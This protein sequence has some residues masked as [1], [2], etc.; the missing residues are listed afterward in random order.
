MAQTKWRVVVEL[1]TDTEQNDG[2]AVDAD[3][4]EFFAQRAIERYIDSPGDDDDD[5]MADV[6]S[7]EVDSVSVRKIGEVAS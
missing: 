7:I 3:M 6:D 5:P 4:I 1:T 2:S